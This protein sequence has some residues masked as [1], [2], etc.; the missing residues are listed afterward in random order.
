MGGGILTGPRR[1]GELNPNH[2]VTQE[3]R[4]QWYKLCACLMLKFGVDTVDLTSADIEKLSSSGRANITV[5]PAGDVITLALV[6]DS[7]ALRLARREGG[8][9][10]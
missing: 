2:P 3:L 4:E 6:S 5:R 10:V 9:P 1:G 8:L 7:E